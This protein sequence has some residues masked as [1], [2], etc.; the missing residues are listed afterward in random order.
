MLFSVGVSFFLIMSTLLQSSTVFLETFNVV[1]CGSFSLSDH[2]HTSAELNGFLETFNVVFCRSFS[3][4][5]HVHPSAELN[6]FLRNL[7]CCYLW[8]FL[9]Y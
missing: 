5:D 7:K 4:A 3:L 6:G 2:V 1:F 9:S 8:E